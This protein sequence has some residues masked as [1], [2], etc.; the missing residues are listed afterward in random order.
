HGWPEITHV[1]GGG[2]FWEHEWVRMGGACSELKSCWRGGALLMALGALVSGC[3]SDPGGSSSPGWFSS[4]RGGV[5]GVFAGPTPPVPASQ[6]PGAPPLPSVDDDCPEVQIRGGASTLAVSSKTE[7]GAPG[8]LRYQLT[9]TQ[10]ARQCT[11]AGSAMRIRVGV[12][13]RVIAGPAG[14]PSQVEVPVR[15]AVVR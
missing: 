4:V 7:Q 12:Q 13:G 15:D 3:S 8:D 5:S 11:I 1:T 9:F 2:R 6:A 10:T 14:A